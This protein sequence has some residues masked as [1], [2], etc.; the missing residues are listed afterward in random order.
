MGEELVAKELSVLS[1]ESVVDVGVRV[2]AGLWE[3]R[4][5]GLS[6]IRC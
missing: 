4:G 3:S 1:F 2:L 6:S 5:N